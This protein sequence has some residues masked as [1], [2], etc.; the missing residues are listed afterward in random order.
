LLEPPKVVEGHP[1][2]SAS[3]RK[4]SISRPSRYVRLVPIAT[5]MPRNKR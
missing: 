5:F 3:S 2:L 1:G 4:R